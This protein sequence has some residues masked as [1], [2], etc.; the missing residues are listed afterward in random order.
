MSLKTV[1]LKNIEETTKHISNHF[2]LFDCSHKFLN[3]ADKIFNYFPDDDCEKAVCVISA[4]VSVYNFC[5]KSHNKLINYQSEPH[6]KIQ[7]FDSINLIIR[8]NSSKLGEVDTNELESLQAFFQG[9]YKSCCHELKELIKYSKEKLDTEFSYIL[10][11]NKIIKSAYIIESNKEKVNVNINDNRA[12]K[13]FL[14]QIKKSKLVVKSPDGRFAKIVDN[15]SQ[16]KTII[17]PMDQDLLNELLA[18]IEK[19]LKPKT[20]WLNC[21]IINAYGKY[22]ESNKNEEVFVFNTAFSAILFDEK[23]NKLNYERVKNH[24][25]N[26]D[27]FNKKY[28]FIPVNVKSNHWTLIAVDM[29]LKNIF[30]Y[31]S[32]LI[33][34]NEFVNNLL[35]AVQTFLVNKA[36]DQNEL[37]FLEGWK[38]GI[39]TNC[40]KQLN[41]HDCGVFVCIFMTLISAGKSTKKYEPGPGHFRELMTNNLIL[42]Y[43]SYVTQ[44][45]KNN[46]TDDEGI[47]YKNNKTDEYIFVNSENYIKE[48][49]NSPTSNIQNVKYVLTIENKNKNKFTESLTSDNDENN[50]VP[51]KNKSHFLEITSDDENHAAKKKEE[52]INPALNI[53]K[54]NKIVNEKNLVANN[55][56]TTLLKSTVFAVKNVY[57][58]LVDKSNMVNNEGKDYLQVGFC[59]HNFFIEIAN[60]ICK[61]GGECHQESLIKFI[62]YQFNDINVKTFGVLKFLEK[63]KQL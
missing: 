22:V 53:Q 56:D 35:Q 2:S 13:Q 21:T 40:D 33:T 55:I 10:D 43:R 24:T 52:L 59:A 61:V 48:E 19:R 42:H 12:T 7:S 51:K 41:G 36:K 6:D 50:D 49:K 39:K 28:L 16:T 45:Y 54:T 27:M 1:L 14:L 60:Q 26:A 58:E 25:K 62:L 20:E 32:L 31:D 47:Q 34:K 63:K 5:I 29:T 3:L 23:T 57:K 4:W 17:Q 37:N 9:F 30:Y 18:D 38:T 15:N 46:D 8:R 44:T 11:S